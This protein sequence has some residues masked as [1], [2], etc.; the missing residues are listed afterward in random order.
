MHGKPPANSHGR[1]RWE[2]GGD[3]RKK[4]VL[5]ND[6]ELASVVKHNGEIKC[7]PLSC[8]VKHNKQ[9]RAPLTAKY[10]SGN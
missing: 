1:I 7:D 3:Q 5:G 4:G 9:V 6:R 8:L 2:K 10:E